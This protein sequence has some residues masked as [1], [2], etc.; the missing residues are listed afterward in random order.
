MKKNLVLILVLAGL[1]LLLAACGGGKASTNLK[2]AMTDFK[3]DPMEFTIPAGKEIT[4]DAANNGAVVHE[5]VIMKLGESVGEKFGPEDE[6]NIFWE[7]EVDPG[8]TK[9]VTFTAPTEPGEYQVVCG[10]EGHYAAGMVAKL[11][12]V[13][14]DK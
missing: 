10:T 11:T 14:A 12:V 5:F 6:G 2:V 13:A 1:T 8:A 7:V 4:L 9:T 3:Y